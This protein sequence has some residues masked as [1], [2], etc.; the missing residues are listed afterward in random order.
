MQVENSRL[1]ELNPAS[2]LVE[3]IFTEKFNLIMQHNHNHHLIVQKLILVSKF[4]FYREFSLSIFFDYFHSYLNRHDVDCLIVQIAL[5]C[6]FWKNLSQDPQTEGKKGSLGIKN[7]L[8]HPSFRSFEGK[9]KWERER[10]REMCAYKTRASARYDHSWKNQVE[11]RWSIYL[12]M[13]YKK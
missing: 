10:N 9:S 8:C 1:S 2:S 7:S 13:M 4:L 11:R 3:N 5:N 6:I 12:I